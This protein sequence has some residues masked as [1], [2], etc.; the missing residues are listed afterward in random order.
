[1][2]ALILTLVFLSAASFIMGVYFT[3]KDRK[4]THTAPA[5]A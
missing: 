1:M 4:K 3:F 2:K 5:A